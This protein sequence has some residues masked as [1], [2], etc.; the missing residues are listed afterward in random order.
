MTSKLNLWAAG[1]TLLLAGTALAGISPQLKCASDKS[2]EVGKYMDCRQKAASKFFLT[3]SNGVLQAAQQKCLTDYNLKWPAL[4]AKAVA[5]GAACL[6]TGDQG[7]LQE[8]ID[9]TTDG[10]FSGLFGDPLP[11]PNCPADLLTTQGYLSTC[12]SGLTACTGALAACLGA[13]PS[14]A[15]HLLQTGQTECWDATGSL[16]PCSGT[17]QDGELQKGL[18]RVYVD[19]GDGTITD[20][21]TGLMWE[22]LSEDGSIHDRNT[23][24]TWADAFAV[25]VAALN[26]GGGFAGYTDWRVPNVNELQSLV[27]YGGPTTAPEFNTVCAPGCTVLTCSCTW[28]GPYHSSTSRQ[29]LPTFVWQVDFSYGAVYFANNFAYVRAVRGGS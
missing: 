19:N 7:V 6:S 21:R 17:G 8:L 16:V 28:P 25:K 24:Y 23:R 9:N 26:G 15:G 3:T 22:K 2:K 29:D 18:S 20:M 12:Q 14:P 27:N 5:A 4:E 13:C 1:A 11:P 10:I